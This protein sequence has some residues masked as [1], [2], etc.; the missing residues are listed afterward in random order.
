MSWG[1]KV[2]TLR[3]GYSELKLNLACG[4]VNNMNFVGFLSRAQYVLI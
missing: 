3:E 4:V 2:F 1:Y